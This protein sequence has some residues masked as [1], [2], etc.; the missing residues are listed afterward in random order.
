MA[1]TFEL[2]SSVTVGSGGASDITLSSIP[3]TY[4]DICI[5]FSIRSNYGSNYDFLG[6]NINGTGNGTNISSKMLWGDGSGA[7][8]GSYSFIGFVNGNAATSNTFGNGSIY[9][10]NYAGSTNKSFS[11][12]SVTENNA[13]TAYD[14]IS[15]GLWSNTAAITS[16]KLYPNYGSA[17]LEHSTA[18]IYGVKNA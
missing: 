5:Q 10:P 6:I 13:T 18:Y 8:T 16:I 1:N 15:A 12:D 11:L 9:F 2:I 7:L 17:F 14:N 4:T 3:S